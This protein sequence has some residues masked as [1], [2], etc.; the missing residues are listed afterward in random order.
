MRTHAVVCHDVVK[1]DPDL[2]GF[3]GVRP[4]RSKLSMARFRAHLD[5][6]EEALNNEPRVVDDRPDGRA[7]VPRRV[8]DRRAPED[9]AHHRFAL[10]LAPT[11]EPVRTTQ[12]GWECLVVGRF[13]VRAS[14]FAVNASRIAAGDSGPWLREWVGWNLRGPAKAMFGKRYESL[15]GGVLSHRPRVERR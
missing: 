10:S 5:A 12:P 4:A 7:R 9:G 8:E 14:T 3:G 11:S 2:S 13:S 1:G 15:R 6:I